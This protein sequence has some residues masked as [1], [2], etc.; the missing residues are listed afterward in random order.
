MKK[1]VL[2][3][4]LLSIFMPFKVK[5]ADFSTS[6][7]G[8]TS[9]V[10][11]ETFT[12]TFNAT[13]STSL[14]AISGS[15]SYDSN[16]LTIINSN[17]ING[18]N[19]TLGSKIVVDST[20]GKTGT[21]GF[22]TI[23]FKATNNFQ[24]GEST[25]INFSNV[26]GSDGSR[27]LSG[28]GSSL[29]IT[30]KSNN[31]N[32]STLTVNGTKV[33]DF[34]PNRTSYS[35]TVENKITTAVIAATPEDSR[36]TVAGAGVKNLN[37]YGNT[38]NIVVTAQNGSKKTYTLT[39]IR[40]NSDGFTA[41]RS[42]NNNLSNITIEGY[43]I[44]FDKNTLEYEI[45]VENNVT[46]LDIKTTLEDNKASVTIDKSD[47]LKVGDNTINIKVTAEDGTEKIYK[48]K[49][50]R[51]SEGPTTTIKELGNII[52]KTTSKIINIDIKDNYNILTKEILSSLNKNKKKVL[53]SKYA[54]DKIIYK[55]EID[56]NNI[57]LDKE[58][59]TLIK[60]NTSDKEL[61][62]LTNY[63]NN[64]YLSFAHSGDLPKDT[65]LDIYVGDKFQDGS[66]LRLYY[67]NDKNKLEEI[68]DELKVKDGYVRFKLEH[69]SN[70]LLT[71]SNYNN[72]TNP[73]LIYQII[74]GVLSAIIIAFIVVTILLKRKIN[75]LLI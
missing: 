29:T 53:I 71:M 19:L 30:V 42:N 28:T 51:K 56:G 67:Y 49:V 13:S 54:D 18:F 61:D 58:I 45:T 32:L 55:W 35:M 11:G 8:T 6:V 16:K 17:G 7:S 33:P 74:I 57:K 2:F 3:T 41:P 39:I 69:C 68:Y 40:K 66:K 75:D 62:E 65:Y 15:L 14:F 70:Y 4:L 47:D 48:I 21:F 27:D 59:N 73:Y 63:G 1:L 37:V 5:A 20:G 38:F 44:N 12:V 22:T 24:V 23:T 10:P 25:T 9:I 64:L 26:A 46:S 36:S 34:S 43:T 52:D 72:N 50:K 60:I 31:N